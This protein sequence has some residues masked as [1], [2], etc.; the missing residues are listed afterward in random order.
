VIHRGKLPLTLLAALAIPATSP[1]QAAPETNVPAVVLPDWLVDQAD[2]LLRNAVAQVDEERAIQLL[3]TLLGHLQKSSPKQLAEFRPTAAA[4]VPWLEQ[5]EETI[6]YAIWLRTRLDYFDAA[7]ELSRVPKPAEPPRT[8]V[9]PKPTVFD[10]QLAK[11]PAPPAAQRYLEPLKRAFAAE[12]VPPQ[13]VWLAEVESSFD[14]R[15][16]SP[17]GAAGLFQL[18]KPTA[19]SLG[20]S[21]WLPDERLNPEKSAHAAAA[22][23]RQLFQR[24]RDWPLA[25]AAYNAGETRVASL[26]RQA[27]AKSFDAIAPKLPTET[28]L[29]VPKVEATLR[30]RE[31][32]ELRKLPPPKP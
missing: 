31:A 22:Y 29:Y 11:R 4:L 5:N 3:D 14:P 19:Q 1:A 6:P 28:Q 21:T 8:D 13:L 25:L 10:Q 9:A 20:L 12:K 2:L 24:F 16:K 15:A 27:S 26:L 23:L 18:T 30:K 17:A 32:V 7:S